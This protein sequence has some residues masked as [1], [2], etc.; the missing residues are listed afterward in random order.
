MTKETEKRS[1]EALA[2]VADYICQK[3]QI[4]QEDIKD[5]DN[6]LDNIL[7]SMNNEGK[8]FKRLL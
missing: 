4:G 5:L 6:R 2:A 3:K 1:I 7:A 8:F